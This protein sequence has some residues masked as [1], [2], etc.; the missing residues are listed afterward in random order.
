[1]RRR[2]KSTVI[3][4][5]C[6]PQRKINSLTLRR[7]IALRLSNASTLMKLHPQEKNCKNLNPHKRTKS[8]DP[9]HQPTSLQNKSALKIL[10][11]TPKFLILSSS[12]PAKSPALSTT[13]SPCVSFLNSP[14]KNSPKLSTNSKRLGNGSKAVQW[15][16]TISKLRKYKRSRNTRS[17]TQ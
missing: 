16:G 8:N 3:T 5:T 13:F 7:L 1:M 6:H 10:T 12:K 11:L 9:K 14:Y 2:I 17:V 4:S 15:N